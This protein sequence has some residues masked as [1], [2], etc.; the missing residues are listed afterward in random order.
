MV[1]AAAGVLVVTAQFQ[2][3]AT[4]RD[5]RSIWLVALYVGL[6]MATAVAAPPALPSASLA[7]APAAGASLRA[8]YT[9]MQVELAQ[10]EF[11]QP[12]VVRSEEGQGNIVGEVFAVVDFSLTQVIQGLDSPQ[13]WCDIMILHINTKYCSAK[14]GPQGMQLAVHIGKKTPENLVYTRPLVLNYLPHNLGPDYLNIGLMAKEGPIG[15]SDYEILLEAVALPGDRSFLHLSYSYKVNMMGKLALQTY[16]GTAG[17]NKVGFSVVQRNAVGQPVL[18]GGVRGVVERN[19]MR[20]YLAINAYLAAE[21]LPP[22]ERQ[23]ARLLNWIVATERYPL[24]LQEVDRASYLTMKRAELL[25]QQTT[26]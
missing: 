14:P 16:L 6:Q 7:T 10:S 1:C 3:K 22:Q 12:L 9:A 4:L 24:Q 21:R 18:M 19:T 11:L 13:R 17:R 15:T 8:Q 25:R 2:P 26:R 23:E 20:Y 5:R